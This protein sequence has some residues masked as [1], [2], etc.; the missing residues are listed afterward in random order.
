[1]QPILILADDVLHE[2]SL[3]KLGDG[4]VRPSWRHARHGLIKDVIP[5]RVLC[6]LAALQFARLS[7]HQTFG[8]RLS[9]DA[10]WPSVVLQAGIRADASDDTGGTALLE[11]I[12]VVG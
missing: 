1:M 6:R 4:S 11:G 5:R 7:A 2:A 10:L 9:P 12:A 3:Y 8:A